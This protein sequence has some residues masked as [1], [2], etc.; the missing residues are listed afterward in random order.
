MRVP[1][2]TQDCTGHVE[3]R[4]DRNCVML[5]TKRLELVVFATRTSTSAPLCRAKY[6][7]VRSNG[8]EARG[9]P[10]QP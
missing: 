6:H 2:A 8:P 4:I 9:Q 3:D 1:D 7:E 5:L 10:G